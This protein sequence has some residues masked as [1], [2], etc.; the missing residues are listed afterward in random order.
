MGPNFL[1]AVRLFTGSFSGYVGTGSNDTATYTVSVQAMGAGGGAAGRTALLV[2]DRLA[3]YD[4][5]YK[6][7]IEGGAGGGGA[8]LDGTF[9]AP[10]SAYITVAV[11]APGTNGIDLQELQTS[12]NYQTVQ[13]N[14]NSNII[15]PG[16]TFYPN[17]IPETKHN[18]TDGG[19]VTIESAD[20][21]IKIRVQGGKGAI[22]KATSV[23]G[24]DIPF[25]ERVPGAQN[26]TIRTRGK[27]AVFGTNYT[28]KSYNENPSPDVIITTP[29]A[30]Q[31]QFSSGIL[32]GQG[33][34]SSR[35]NTE[36]SFAGDIYKRPAGN[37]YCRILSVRK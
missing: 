31:S 16:E 21:T 1:T 22:C 17:A 34:W 33:G 26:F 2:P 23:A 10:G 36:D 28:L 24:G 7:V 8:Y 32:A 13:Y 35:G 5:K 9:E 11:A 37:G 4:N 12:L 29:Q 3:E 20:A 15:S 25:I 18:G 6:V 14:V 27:D 19:N 30:P